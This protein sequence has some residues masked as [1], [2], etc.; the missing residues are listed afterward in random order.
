MSKEE[1][2]AG[3]A[4]TRG[5][6]KEGDEHRTAPLCARA[7]RPPPRLPRLLHSYMGG[8]GWHT[9]VG[10]TVTGA[11]ALE[12]YRLWKRHRSSGGLSAEEYTSELLPWTAAPLAGILLVPQTRFALLDVAFGGLRSINAADARALVVE[13][14]PILGPKFG[15]LHCLYLSA[16]DPI[17]VLVWRDWATRSAKLTP[18]AGWLSIGSGVVMAALVPVW[19]P[20]F[21]L[22]VPRL[23]FR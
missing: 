6:G 5:T 14:F 2:A 20:S 12:L 22:T 8:L 9:A 18:L 23:P 11:V 16:Q 15:V 1:R 3:P 17:T 21:L 10:A 19:G 4:R 13:R 7:G